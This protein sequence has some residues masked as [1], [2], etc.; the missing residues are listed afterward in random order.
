[1]MGYDGMC[2]GGREES[3]HEVERLAENGKRHSPVCKPISSLIPVGLAQ[4]SADMYIVQ[5]SSAL[6][7][8]R[9]MPSC[10]LHCVACRGERL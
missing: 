9:H 7:P 5:Y 1:M 6:F 8:C 4:G 10:T 3:D 2:C